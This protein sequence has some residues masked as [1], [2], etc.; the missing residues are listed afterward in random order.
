MSIAAPIILTDGTGLA[1][2]VGPPTASL[3]DARARTRDFLD[4][5][6]QP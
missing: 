5:L 1:V 6:V 3:G 4:R 2:S